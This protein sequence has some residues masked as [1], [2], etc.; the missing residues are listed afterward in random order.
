MDKDRLLTGLRHATS[1]LIGLALVAV[2][3]YFGSAQSLERLGRLRP[4]PTLLAFAATVGLTAT[5]ASRWGALVNQISGQTVARWRRYY[6]YFVLSRLLGF[7]LPKDVTDLGSRTLCLNRFHRVPLASAGAS[8]LFDRLFDLGTAAA[9]FVAVL[10]YWL[11]WVSAENAIIL[12]PA[13][14]VA[15]GATLGLSPGVSRAPITLFNWAL[16]TIAR[17]R[18]QPPTA[19]PPIS[20]LERRLVLKLYGL[21]L[22]KF[23]LAAG[24]MALFSA[25]LGLDLD[26]RLFFLGTPLAQL[27]YAVAFTPGGLGIYEAGWFGVLRYAGV[28]AFDAT[29]LVIG[30]RVLTLLMI[31]VL[32]GFSQLWTS[33][34]AEPLRQ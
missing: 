31:G 26:P 8:V 29:A 25:A 18:R 27:T 16:R 14:A 4:A 5:V 10:P 30:Q 12:M 1:L 13:M 28:A 9:M 21:S 7:A 3:V 22:L 6:H 23:A 24:R 19:K 32:A 33:I 20:E 2:I 11:G 34:A 17:F 15:V